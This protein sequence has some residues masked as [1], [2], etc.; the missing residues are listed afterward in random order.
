[1]AMFL[2]YFYAM[3]GLAFY[4]AWLYFMA[5]CVVRVVVATIK[6]ANDPEEPVGGG[7]V[8]RLDA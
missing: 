5:K 4:Y 7:A 3:L 2:Y 6:T 8:Q 1:M